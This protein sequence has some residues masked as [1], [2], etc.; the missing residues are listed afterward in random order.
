V[1]RTLVARTDGLGDVLLT[2]PAV[3]AIAASGADVTMLVGPAGAPAAQ[4][5]PAVRDIVVQRLPWI[6][7]NP[8]PAGRAWFD[9][10]VGQ[11]AAGSFDNAVIFT[12]FHQNALPLAL[13]CRLAGI[14]HVAAISDDYAGS[15]LDICHRVPPGVHEVERNLSLVRACGM[16]LPVGDD[17]GLAVEVRTPSRSPSDLP[18][19]YV[20]VHPAASAPAR[21]LSSTRWKEIAAALS[22]EGRDVLV[23]GGPSDI[24][25]TRRVTAQLSDRVR[26]LG[27][28]C[29]FDGFTAVIAGADAVIVGNAGP[30]H[31]AAA[32]GTP[33]VSIFAPTVPAVRWRPWMVRHVMLGD[34]LIACRDC[35]SRVCPFPDQP[36]VCPVSPRDVIR[37]LRV[38][39]DKTAM[40]R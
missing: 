13:A 2:G 12:S 37:A 19:R 31:L 32:V 4:R 30:A 25:L 22:N 18:D 1:T 24:A 3:R 38:L 35:G 34:Q 7:A 17:G 8:Q 33:V 10:F 29:D 28:A 20:V 26:D 27:G 14:D 5:L 6:D 39:S 36:C 15:L 16:Q 23:T 40:F 11:I 21:T 9:A